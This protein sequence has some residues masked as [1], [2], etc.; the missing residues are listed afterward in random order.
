MASVV[1]VEAARVEEV[2]VGGRD[3]GGADDEAVGV[4]FG[5]RYPGHFELFVGLHFGEC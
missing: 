1:L 4:G 2:D 5:G 3:V